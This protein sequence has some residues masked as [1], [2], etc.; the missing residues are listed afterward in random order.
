MPKVKAV[1]LSKEKGIKKEVNSIILIENFGIEGD[2]HFKKD[3]NRQVSILIY[4]IFNEKKEELHK[5]NIE[6]QY[7][8]F[9][10]NIILDNINFYNIKIGT[11]FIFES[12]VELEVSIIGKDCQI[13]CIIQKKT[14][15][16]IMPEYGIFCKVIKGGIIKNGDSCHYC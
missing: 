12:G 7:G 11:K 6:I 3:S 9:G 15:S 4:E 8:V 16:C 13:P 2:F 1:C 5:N 10:E 14:G